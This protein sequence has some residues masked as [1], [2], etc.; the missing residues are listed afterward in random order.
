MDIIGPIGT[1]EKSPK[2]PFPCPVT[3]GKGQR[4][5]GTMKL[6]RRDFFE[7]D[8]CHRQIANRGAMFRHK[9]SVLITTDEG[10]QVWLFPESE[11]GV[12]DSR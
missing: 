1:E 8:R 11:L 2:G 5:S 6:N 4:C 9:D 10:Y 12:G 3:D 7:C